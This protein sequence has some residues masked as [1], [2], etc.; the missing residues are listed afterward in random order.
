MGIDTIGTN[1]IKDNAVTAPKIVAGAV[2]TDI[3][4]GA[5]STAMLADNAVTSAKIL[6]GNVITAKLGDNAITTVK[7]NADA[8]T[9]AKIAAGAVQ[10]SELDTDAVI[11]SKIAGGAVTNGKLATDAVT[12]AKITDGTITAADLGADS[13]GSSE[14]ATDAV[15]S[16]EIAANAVGSSE[17]DLTADY[18][19]TSTLKAGQWQDNV[20][21]VSTATSTSA[22]NLS[23]GNMFQLTLNAS[24][25]TTVTFSN[26]PAS[27]GLVFMVKIVQP[28][29]GSTRTVT[30]PT[31]KWK[32]GTAPAVSSGNGDVDIF[33]F[34][35]FGG[36]TYYGFFAGKDVS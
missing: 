35:T 3:A 2:A 4:N 6:D 23:T 20:V 12:S 7:I 31:A 36:S 33:V 10:S 15:G 13:V 27:S 29:S 19:Y 25:D 14:I 21:G 17:I 1:A 9:S 32:D 30:W 26:P 24:H 5:I 22:I 34:T 11:A 18:T 8:V 28:S 16:A